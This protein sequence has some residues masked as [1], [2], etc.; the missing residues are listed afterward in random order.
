MSVRDENTANGAQAV[1]EALYPDG[2]TALGTWL[3]LAAR[4]FDSAG[5]NGARHVTIISDGGN[6]NE[7]PAQFQTALAQTAGRLRADVLSI[8]TPTWELET[9]ASQLGGRAMPLP[10][11]NRLSA[12]LQ[13]ML[14][15]PAPGAEPATDS[16]P[17]TPARWEE[18]TIILR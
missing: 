2:G 11:P 8:G 15:K 1:I 9:L 13:L 14:P 7:S 4:L 18:D 16:A 5:V 12:L 10:W 6:G 3:K 17:A